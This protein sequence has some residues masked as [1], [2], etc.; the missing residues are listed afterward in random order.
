[1][2]KVTKVK[3]V[4]SESLRKQYEACKVEIAQL[5]ESSD[6]QKQELHGAQ[7][8]VR[9]LERMVSIHTLLYLKD[10]RV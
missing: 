10:T 9:Y 5:K 1:M 6:A 2:V 8:Q 3:Q 4:E 7:D